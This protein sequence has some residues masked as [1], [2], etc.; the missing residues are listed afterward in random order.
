MY[1]VL[2]VDDEPLARREL[3]K[4]LESRP[5]I[6]KIDIAEDA[7]RAL[8]MLQANEFDVV[9]LDINMPEISGIE[10]LELSQQKQ[11]RL[12]AVVF[13]T[14]YSE[15]AVAAFEHHAVDYVLKPISSTRIFKALEVAIR[16][17][18][19]E[20]I[21]KLLDALPELQGL[22]NQKPKRIAIKVQGRIVFVNPSEIMFVQAE[23]NY[24]L[25]QGAH[26]S[27]LLRESMNQVEQ[28]LARHGFVR[29]H[30]SVIVNSQFVREFRPCYTG[31][32]TL[33]LV[34]GKE[35]TVTRTYK[36]NLKQFATD[37]IGLDTSSTEP[38]SLD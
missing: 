29:I 13:V 9:F 17:S 33:T 30:R 6:S 10:L 11:V 20:R 32:Y 2:I 31:E 19:A 34:N 26:G 1:S 27:H 18:E 22:T 38:D 23:G 8:E 36:K 35:F 24:V 21:S 3:V 25:L 28:K 12:P 7:S 14:A 4:V 15:Y 16:R 5:D 37:V